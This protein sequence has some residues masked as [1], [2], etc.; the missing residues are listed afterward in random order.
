[1]LLGSSQTRLP[2]S[3]GDIESSMNLRL[4]FLSFALIMSLA[5]TLGACGKKAEAPPAPLAATPE[6]AKP[7]PEPAKPAPEAAKPEP[8][9]PEAAKPAEPEPAKPAE[10]EAVKPAEPEAVKPAEPEAA[11]PAEAAEGC[12][13]LSF[14][15]LAAKAKSYPSLL[16]LATKLYSDSPDGPPKTEE[17]AKEL[18]WSYANGGRD[19]PPSFP[20]NGIFLAV[21][22]DYGPTGSIVSLV[23]PKEGAKGFWVAERVTVAD[24]PAQGIPGKKLTENESIFD[25]VLAKSG[26]PH[27]IAPYFSYDENTEK[28]GDRR[29]YETWVDAKTGTQIRFVSTDSR[30]DQQNLPEA[31]M[32]MGYWQGCNQLFKLGD[33]SEIGEI[34]LEP[35]EFKRNFE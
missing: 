23:V 25:A 13:L 24:P 18:L 10:P 1:M 14:G 5:P 8:A 22:G 3:E 21:T 19:N 26:E 28:Y 4:N 7:A 9:K 12:K 35:A 20:A 31:I 2:P 29:I 27:A 32:Q 30:K 16:A 17:A 11:K 34:G 33:E 6:P 15:R